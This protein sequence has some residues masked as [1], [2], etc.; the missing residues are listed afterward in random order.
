MNI[1]IAYAISW[2][3]T[4]LVVLIIARALLSW[5]PISQGGILGAIFVLVSSITEPII[6][7][8]RRLVQRSPLGGG[9]MM[10]DFSPMIAML[11]I[12]FITTSLSNLFMSM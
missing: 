3:G 5:F 8:I 6:Y 7:P 11:L 4:L 10:I 2:I 9:G 12:R 1:A